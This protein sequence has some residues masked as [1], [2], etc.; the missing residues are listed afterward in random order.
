MKPLGKKSWENKD[1]PK[2][3]KAKEIRES[4]R[5]VAATVEEMEG[6]WLWGELDWPIWCDDSESP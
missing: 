1:I 3:Y 5:L 2:N 6:D 4:S